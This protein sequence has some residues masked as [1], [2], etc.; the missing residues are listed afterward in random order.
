MY[1]KSSEAQRAALLESAQYPQA[2]GAAYAWSLCGGV[3]GLWKA[4]T[5]RFCGWRAE[6]Q[7]AGAKYVP[8][9]AISFP[10]SKIL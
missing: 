5:I 3:H 8:S 6:P 4:A 9:P 10:S 2:L 7:P 1:T